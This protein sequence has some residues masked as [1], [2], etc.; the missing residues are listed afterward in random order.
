M[1]VNYLKNMASPPIA[2]EEGGIAGPASAGKEMRSGRKLLSFPEK[3]VNPH[4]DAGEDMDEDV[5]H[6]TSPSDPNSSC[7]TSTEKMTEKGRQIR[8]I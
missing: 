2:G 1:K 5:K 6:T 3:P 4:K 7:T 8:R